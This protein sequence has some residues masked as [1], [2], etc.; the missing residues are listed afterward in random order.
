MEKR[1]WNDEEILADARRRA[2]GLDDSPWESHYTPEELARFTRYAADYEVRMDKEWKDVV[3]L[4][5]AG[6]MAAGVITLV[7]LVLKWLGIS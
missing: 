2:D 3:G 4:F 5:F 6:P 1:P 7:V